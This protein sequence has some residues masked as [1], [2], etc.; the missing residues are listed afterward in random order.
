M[1][2]IIARLW[3]WTGIL[4]PSPAGSNPVTRTNG[5]WNELDSHWVH[6]SALWKSHDRWKSRTSQRD[7]N[8]STIFLRV[9]VKSLAEEAKIIRFEERKQHWRFKMAKMLSNE[10]Q[11][12]SPLYF[13]LKRHRLYD[14]RSEARAALLAYAFLRNKPL[15]KVEGVCRELPNW[16]RVE[17]LVTKYGPAGAADGLKLWTETWV[18][19]KGRYVAK[20]YVAPQIEFKPRYEGPPK[21]SPAA[22]AKREKRRLLRLQEGTMGVK[23][24]LPK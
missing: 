2:S 4:K 21:L 19:N 20:G 17:R 14:V 9:K 24:N 18:D 16:G 5:G 1:T 7:P 13:E 15:H 6:N 8:M 12:L 23:P 10:E 3:Q 22:L 11:K